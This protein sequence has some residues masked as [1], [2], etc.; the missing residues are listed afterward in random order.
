MIIYTQ[1]VLFP[2]DDMVH[3]KLIRLRK[4]QIYHLLGILCRQ[5]IVIAKILQVICANY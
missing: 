3:Q 4:S 1:Q 5:L 2:Q